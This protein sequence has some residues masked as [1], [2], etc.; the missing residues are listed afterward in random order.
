V[1]RAG[2]QDLVVVMTGAAASSLAAPLSRAPDPAAAFEVLRRIASDPALPDW[3]LELPEVRE[4][5]L[6]VQTVALREPATLEQLIGNRRHEYA[7]APKPEGGQPWPAGGD[8][9]RFFSVWRFIDEGW[10]FAPGTTMT[11]DRP[12]W[13]DPGAVRALEVP[14]HEL[15]TGVLM[16][17]QWILCPLSLVEPVAW[18]AQLLG[19]GLDS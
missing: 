10:Y 15:L 4:H 8:D 5:L 1:V 2:G 12:N 7:L 11:Q 17:M 18:H 19:G 14:L 9:L 3:S 6:A 13:V 16:K